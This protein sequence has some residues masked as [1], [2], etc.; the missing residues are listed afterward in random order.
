MDP[1]KGE[2]VHDA[3]HKGKLRI[4][5]FTSRSRTEIAIFNLY[6]AFPTADVALYN[7]TLT[8]LTRTIKDFNLVGS[9]MNLN[10]YL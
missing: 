9:N 7:S 10:V 1:R 8:P 6:Y 5:T 3:N 2:K 4:F